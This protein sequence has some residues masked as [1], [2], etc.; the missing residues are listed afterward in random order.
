MESKSVAIIGAGPSGLVAA[1]V[2][3]KD[4]FNVT[5]FERGRYI[6]GMW[7]EDNVYINLHSQQFGGTIEF[8]DLFDGEEFASWQHIHDYLKRYADQC[9][10]TERIKFQTRVI[11]VKKKNLKD[12][13]IPWQIKVEK[14]DGQYEIYEFGFLI[15]ATSLFNEPYMPY[16]RGQEKFTG[17]IIHGHSLKSHEQLIDKRVVIIGGGKCAVDLAST[18]GSYAR[19][20]H[21]ILRRAHWMLPH[22]MVGGLLP[23]RCILTRLAQAPYQPFPGA[24][25]SKLFQCLHRT[26]PRLFTFITDKI[27]DDIIAINGSDLYED[28]VF[29][30]NNSFR[31]VENIYMIPQNFI[32]LKKQGRI[33][34]KLDSID[35]IIDSTTIRLKSGEHLQADMIICATGFINRFPFFSD[36]D[37][38]TMGLLTTQTSTNSNIETDLNLYRRIIPVGIPNVAFIGYVICIAQWSVAEVASHWVS[39]YF[40]GR[41]KLPISE[42]E[43]YKEIDETCTFIHKTFNR[44]GCYFF[45]YWLSPIEIYLS[46][47]GLRLKRTHNWITEYFGIYRPERLKGLHEERRAKAAGIIYHHWYFGFQH[48]ILVFLL[49]LFIILLL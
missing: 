14:F 5:I 11:E 25:H 7:C 30:P 23:A 1:N 39:E 17:T 19:S 36:T 15:V 3:L 46:D 44:T 31:N 4:G 48:T 45:Y 33:I 10:L 34:A 21:I 29:L 6:G 20:C 37:A 35:E 43:M 38:K 27:A 13:N 42:R 41:L 24:P 16:I 40:L 32:R 49:L 47:M 26:L 9:H 18:C 28:K 22:T 2:L 8:S 12:G